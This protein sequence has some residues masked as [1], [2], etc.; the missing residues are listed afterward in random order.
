M[1]MLVGY[2]VYDVLFLAA[3]TLFYGGA[4]YGGGWVFSALV[5][6][7][8]HWSLALF[9]AIVAGVL[10]LIGEV[11][12]A[13]SLCPRLAPGRY[14][15]M[16]GA[17][18]YGWLF[19]SLFRRILLGF[20]LQWL[21]FS[22]N[23]LRFL[24]LRALGA[25]VHFTSSVSNDVALLD[26]ALLVLQPGCM[27]GARCLVTGH[28]IEAG[29]LVLGRVEVGEGALLA[30]DVL[31]APGVVIGKRAIVKG[32]AKLSVGAVIGDGAQ[33]GPD[34]FI[35]AGAQIGAKARLGPRTMVKRRQ[36]VEE[37]ARLP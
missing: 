6:H 16:K 27:I 7:R 33:I 10:T 32:A 21:I 31:C 20:G 17:V 28:F 14:P 18:F 34:A 35:D 11:F 37:G 8:M 25:K 22:S 3:A 5:E 12:V 30:T 9:P 26:P 29:K 13:S 24:A 2:L 4:A 23:V 15:M 1:S 19:R 36:V